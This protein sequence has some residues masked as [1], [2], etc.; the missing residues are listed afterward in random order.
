MITSTQNRRVSAAARLRKRGLRDQDRLFLVEGAQAVGEAVDAAAVESVFHIPGSTGRVPEVVAAARRAGADVLEVAPPVMAHLTSAVTPQGVVAVA[1]FVDVAVAE[2]PG[3]GLIPV[4]SSVR[5][6]GNAGT[7]LRS[8]DAAGASG[9]VITRDSVDVYNPKAVRASAGSMFHVPVVRDVHPAEAVAALRDRGARVLAAAADGEVSMY[10]ADLAGPTALL[11]G[12]EA[13]GLPAEVRSL[14]DQ[15]VRV[16]IHGRAESLNLA[17]AAALLMFES[18]RQREVGSGGIGAVVS[19]S[20]HDVRL[21]LTALRGFASTLVDRWDVFDDSSR[22]E[23]VQAVVL[24]VERVSS[25]VTLLVEVARIDQGRFRAR[26]ERRDVSEAVAATADLFLRSRD[27]PDVE[28]TG[29][30][31][32]AVDRDRVQAL[33]LALC[34]GAMWWGQEGPIEIVIRA[35]DGGAV[36]DVHRA[37]TGP[38]EDEVETMFAGPPA[39]GSKIGLY[40]ARRVAEAS[41]GSLSAEGGGGVTFQLRLPG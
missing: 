27:Y 16:P 4:L 17:A 29:S 38:S 41:G 24:D 18:A 31:E 12:N 35:E 3:T 20:V 14:A 11:L 34:D 1:R 40:L 2:L 10:D 37:G 28:A 36:V 39:E 9:V 21:P 8:A 25:M 32:V 19:A 7:I 30:G 33:L 5:D 22:R 23:M 15:T 13:W 6:P 26:G